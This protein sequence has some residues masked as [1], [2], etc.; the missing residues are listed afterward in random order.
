L[1]LKVLFH[2]ARFRR[3]LRWGLLFTFAASLTTPINAAFHLWHVK[4]VFSN[5]DGSVQFIEMFD[6]FGGENFVGGITLRANADGVIRDFV[7]PGNVDENI[8][9]ANRHI[10]IATPGFGSL[11]G[12]VTPNF[13]FDQSTSPFTLPFFNPNASNISITFFGSGDSMSFTGALLP[14]NGVNS[15]TDAGASG[16]PPGPTSISSTVNSPTNFQNQSGSINLSAPTPTGDYNGNNIV[17]AADYVVWRKTLGLTASPN[18][19]GA[20][21]D[22]NGTIGPGDYTYWR[23]R[24]GNPAGSGTL[25]DA[26]I[27]EPTTAALQLGLGM[28]LWWRFRRRHLAG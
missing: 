24:F 23:A 22:S 15:L 21:G 5:A 27:P 17:D 25:A 28:L 7:F 8:N 3:R 12:A 2:M 19:S 9:S 14:E 13:T 18:G 4:E 1:C 20:D 26:A 6:S 11:P 16:F 10:L